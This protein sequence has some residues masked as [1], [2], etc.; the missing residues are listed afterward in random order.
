M[1]SMDGARRELRRLRDKLRSDDREFRAAAPP[2]DE[3][4][5]PDWDGAGLSLDGYARALGD[6]PAED[7]NEDELA[8]RNRLSPYAAVFARLQ[9][10]SDEKEEPVV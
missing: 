5:W 1:T 6:S 7:L 10:D 3:N 8:T 2:V 9:R 4:G